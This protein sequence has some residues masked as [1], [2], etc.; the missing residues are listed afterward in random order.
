MGQSFERLAKVHTST[1]ESATVFKI[2]ADQK[3]PTNL[4]HRTIQHKDER[5]DSLMRVPKHKPASTK[6]DG[7]PSRRINGLT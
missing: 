5:M 7:D 2:K 4:E 6:F 3:I 1:A